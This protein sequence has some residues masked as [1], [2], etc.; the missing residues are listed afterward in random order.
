MIRNLKNQKIKLPIFPF[1]KN[2]KYIVDLL[3]IIDYNDPHDCFQLKN[4]E[5]MDIIKIVCKDL[6]SATKDDFN[7]DLYTFTKFYKTYGADLKFVGINLP[8]DTRFQQSYIEHKINTTNN[9][10]YK[11]QLAVKSSE[12]QYIQ[13]NDTDRAYYMF[14]FA[15]SIEE[16]AEQV[17]AIAKSLGNCRLT[18][19][20][21]KE[22]KIKIIFKINNKNTTV[23]DQLP[24]TRKEPLEDT[25]MDEVIAKYGY[26]PFL[27]ETIQPQGGISFQDERYIKT[28]DGYEA[29]IQVY[30]YPKNVNMFWLST[31]MNI[32]NAIT[33]VDIKTE[34]LTEVKKNINKSIIE[35]TVRYNSAKTTSEERDAQTRYQELVALYDEI[36]RMGEVVKSVTARI[37]LSAPTIEQLDKN[38]QGILNYLEGSEYKGAVFLNESRNEWLSVF[39]SASKQKETEYYRDGQPVLSKT[40]AGGNPFHYTSLIDPYGTYLGYTTA[41]GASGKVLFDLFRITDTRLSYS[42][43]IFGKKGAGKSTLLKKTMQDRILRGDFVRGFDKSGEWTHLVESNGGK[44]IYLDGS[45]GVLNMFEIFKTDESENLSYAMHI[46]K[47]SIIYKFLVPDAD[48]FE[49]FEFERM[50]RKLYEKFNLV[51]KTDANE[52]VQVTGLPP[53]AY[54]TCSD[55]L[56]LIRKE[57]SG[58]ISHNSTDNEKSAAM[59]MLDRL[60]HIE[61]VMENLVTNFGHI[62]DGHTSIDNIFN[63]QLVFFN[64]KNLANMKNEIFSAQL[65]SALSLCWNNVLQIGGNMKQLWEDGKIDW[66]DITR[67]IIFI[68]EAHRIINTNQLAAAEQLLQ[69]ERE[70]RKYLTGVLYASQSVR[71]Y[72]PEGSDQASINVIKTLFEL[73]QYKFIMKQD[74]NSL[75]ALTAIFQN[76]LSETELSHIPRLKKGECI[77]SISGDENVEFKIDVSEQELA[78]FHGGA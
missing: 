49:I 64:I 40:L 41:K 32:G 70:F 50:A 78:V 57:S 36:S 44:I 8:T 65:Y 59:H 68:D 56:H 19:Q 58:L 4:G 3:G 5:Y 24:F 14:I 23:F 55:M 71:D 51:P 69:M 11:Q 29:C 9:Q 67:F 7:F 16:H 38:V 18:K 39:R 21:N 66:Q 31:L 62:F 76:Q 1:K 2:N 48:Q 46:S 74:S 22:E 26:N 77:L 63:T 20:L 27:L 43:L 73:A 60:E 42:G 6:L 72:V 10:I 53:T 33:T 13:H 52:N 54:P 47:L 45:S 37:F 61:L 15:K 30:Q 75:S 35:Q 25:N 12:L 28:G 17:N 34:N